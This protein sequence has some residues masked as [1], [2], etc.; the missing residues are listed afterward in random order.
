MDEGA[1]TSNYAADRETVLKLLNDALATEIV[2]TLRYRRHQFMAQGLAS[3]SIAAEFAEHARE[4]Q[5]HADRIADRITQ[6]DGQ[7]D[8]NPS[9]LLARSH[10]EYV[11]GG[12]LVEMIR[13]NLV[14]ERIAIDT[15]G[16]I[17]RYLG[18]DDPT[19]R[20]MFESIL[21]KEEEHAEDMQDLLGHLGSGPSP[22]NK[23]SA[24]PPG[25]DPSKDDAGVTRAGNGGSP[26]AR[27][28]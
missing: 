22:F 24:T 7:P 6:L 23:E 20:V 18:N 4:E 28:R 14:A 19:T 11:A 12:S 2:C 9:G 21:A 1:V 3:K 10:S 25:K 27:P 26:N 8:F 5:E 15:Y 13:E 16:E 17:V